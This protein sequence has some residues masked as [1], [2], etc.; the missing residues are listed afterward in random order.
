MISK[1][2]DTYRFLPNKNL[3]FEENILRIDSR[4][5]VSTI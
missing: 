3:N 2:Y 5:T 4:N 1:K